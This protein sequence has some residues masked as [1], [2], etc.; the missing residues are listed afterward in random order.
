MKDPQQVLDDLIQ[1]KV[2]LVKIDS[3]FTPREFNIGIGTLHLT[4]TTD[5]RLIFNIKENG[6]L[7]TAFHTD[8]YSQI[9]AKP[10]FLNI[11]TLA[12]KK[13]WNP[14]DESNWELKK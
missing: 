5:M 14:Y 6:L 2:G 7:F 13:G 10:Y 8:D 12:M 9:I 11:I 1:Q 4:R 3:R